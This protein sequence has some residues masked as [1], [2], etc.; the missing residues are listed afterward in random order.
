MNATM[1]G[2]LRLL[3]WLVNAPVRSPS[4]LYLSGP[5]TVAIGLAFDFTRRHFEILG[6]TTSA[7]ERSALFAVWLPLALAFLLAGGFAKI[8]SVP[9]MGTLPKLVEKTRWASL[10]LS[11]GSL[12]PAGAAAALGPD[13]PDG[14][15]PLTAMSVALF[16]FG[17][18]ARSHSVKTGRLRLF[19]VLMAAWAVMN[20]GLLL[21]IAGTSH[22]AAL[23]IASVGI[24]DQLIALR[25][26]GAAAAA[27]IKPAFYPHGVTPRGPLPP[28]SHSSS[29]QPR[30]RAAQSYQRRCRGTRFAVRL[31][32]RIPLAL[33]F[34]LVVSSSMVWLLL[35]G[36][37]LPE[38]TF[39]KSLGETLWGR[40][41]NGESS[42]R[43]RTPIRQIYFPLV[44]LIFGILFHSKGD[45]YLPISRRVRSRAA[46]AKFQI[47]SLVLTS[48]LC[49]LAGLAS[50]A[51]IAATGLPRP[52]HLPGF[53]LVL[54]YVLVALPWMGITALAG[55][56]Q[57]IQPK[58]SLS[59][60]FTK[61]RAFVAA[62]L[63]LILLNGAVFLG[64]YI[65]LRPEGGWLQLP[66]TWA[67]AALLIT[68]GVHQLRRSFDR[69]YNR[70]PLV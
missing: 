31:A 42:L 57:L 63:S 45:G 32:I 25:N 33:A 29:A 21:S 26:Q 58:S 46:L 69:F 34:M 67:A 59:E 17:L 66:W 48:V 62:T 18:G 39:L 65:E 23:L 68:L 8:R 12:F 70:I 38:K 51:A 60:I 9:S 54:P 2:S 53:L 47:H 10:I 6:Y 27:P 13:S 41:S 52:G 7:L 14:V 22:W 19:W 24:L 50:L 61:G 4:G 64:A 5:P 36:A 55:G 1:A 16:A 20:G 15:G 37:E 28:P 30:L 56:E 35:N 11:L 3:P 43:Y 49:L 44:L 40:P